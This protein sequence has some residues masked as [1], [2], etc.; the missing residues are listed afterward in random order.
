MV[1]P[2]QVELPAASLVQQ[3]LWERLRELVAVVVMEPVATAAGV[4]AVQLAHRELVV[5]VVLTTQAVLRVVVVEP[6]DQASKLDQL[7]AREAH[8]RQQ[9]VAVAATIGPEPAALAALA[10]EAVL[11]D[12]TVVVDQALVIIVHRVKMVAQV[13]LAE[14]GTLLM[15]PVVEQVVGLDLVLLVARR[16]LAAYMVGVGVVEVK[17]EAVVERVVQVLLVLL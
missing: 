15:V 2:Q 4:A 17:A 6:V 10:L 3:V 11:L 13:A 12:Q 5:R 9:M 16:A 8:H 1:E 14:I 7:V